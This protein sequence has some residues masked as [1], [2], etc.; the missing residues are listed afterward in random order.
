MNSNDST[1]DKDAE[2]IGKLSKEIKILK[3]TIK[4]FRKNKV[5]FLEIKEAEAELYRLKNNLSYHRIDK[6]YKFLNMM[7]TNPL[8]NFRTNVDTM[9][10]DTEYSH[11]PGLG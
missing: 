8:P 9:Y 1:L 2:I 3:K 4:E 5:S 11:L 7:M 10:W 6:K